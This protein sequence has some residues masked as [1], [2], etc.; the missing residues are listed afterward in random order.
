MLKRNVTFK[1]VVIVIFLVLVALFVFNFNRSKYTS[2]V[3]KV[4]TQ[5]K[6][7]EKTLSADGRV[8]STKEANLAFK[9]SGILQSIKVKEGQQ[10]KQGELLAVKDTS[11]TYLELQAL[12]DARDIAKRDK[13]IYALNYADDTDA[14]GGDD[15][16]NQQIRR[17]DELI[18]KAEAGYQAGLV[19]LGD[20]YLYAPFAGVIV[21][22]NVNEGELISAGAAAFK[23]ADVNDLYFE[24]AVDQEDF[25]NLIN[26]MQVKVS[27][28]S[29]PNIEF[30]GNVYEL[31]QYI[32]INSSENI[33]IK[34]KFKDSDK[35]PLYGMTGEG[36]LILYT[37]GTEVKALAYDEINY[38]EENKAYVWTI[39][40]KG[41]ISKTYIETGLEGDIYTEVKSEISQDI[42]IPANA[43]SKVEEGFTATFINE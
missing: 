41:K 23:I 31:P 29:Y 25:V 10:V 2:V 43:Q 22:K 1:R 32:S 26:D 19:G 20:L 38:D 18:S 15:V 16:Y 4:E 7:V 37:S 14:V 8:T 27:L 3:K 6:I 28:D 13:D 36:A 35:K 9:S 39:D 21:E 33:N 40:D 11:Q 12:K 30:I 34:V 17:L 42:V 24:I 5:N